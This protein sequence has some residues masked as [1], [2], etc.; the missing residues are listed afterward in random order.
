MSINKLLGLMTVKDSRERA[1]FVVFIE[2][3]LCHQLWTGSVVVMDN[4]PGHKLASIV[5]RIESVSAS[6]ICLFPYYRLFESP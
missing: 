1:E 3:F 4:L 2:Q 6:V 5:R